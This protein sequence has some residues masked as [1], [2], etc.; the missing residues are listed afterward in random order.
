MLR[1][2]LD[3]RFLRFHSRT[4]EVSV[5]SWGPL[6]HPHRQ[7]LFV[8]SFLFL[9]P[10]PPSLPLC[11]TLLPQLPGELRG[12]ASHLDLVL[13][14]QRRCYER[15]LTPPLMADWL[16]W[17]L[18]C[19][20]EGQRL[21]LTFWPL[22]ELTPC[23]SLCR[24]DR[25]AKTS[26][27]LKVQIRLFHLAALRC[28]L[29]SAIGYFPRRKPYLTFIVNSW[30]HRAQISALFCPLFAVIS[31]FFFSRIL[32]NCV[33]WSQWMKVL[34]VWWRQYGSCEIGL[35]MKIGPWWKA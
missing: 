21:F 14:H 27:M 33:P 26:Q 23:P 29:L 20:V 4:W 34:M 10:L 18:C 28:S 7:D 1:L 30:A 2:K 11:L 32:I 15:R 16:V 12:G 17:I 5:S 35:V 24:A 9:L 3:F 31:N 6:I 8:G 25:C 13:P 22:A 19:S